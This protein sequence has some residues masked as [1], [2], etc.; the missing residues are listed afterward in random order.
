MNTSAVDNLPQVA[1][2][3]ERHV[4]AAEEELRLEVSFHKQCTCRITL[5]QGSCELQGVELAVGKPTVF[6]D[7]GGLKIALFTWYGCVVDVECGDHMESSYTS[8]ET[9]CNVAYV[10]T[11][12][13]LEA[14]R[15]EAALAAT[16]AAASSAVSSVTAAGG[17]DEN[18]SGNADNAEYRK[19][20]GPRVLICGPAESGKSSLAKVLIAYAVKLGRS[21]VWVDLDPADNNVGVPGTLA[22]C[23]MNTREA[24]SL[25]TW[26]Y[27]GITPVSSEEQLPPT[28]SV[29]G[30]FPSQQQSSSQSSPLMLWHGTAGQPSPDLFK[31]Q[32]TALASKIDR[33]LR[34]DDWARSSG[35]IVNTN[36]WIR[37]EGYQ[38][39][40]HAV[41][42]L[43][44]DVVLVM[45]H[46]RLYSMMRQSIKKGDN[47]GIKVIKVPRSGGVV[48]RDAT[49]LRQ[50]RSRSMKRYF[51]GDLVEASAQ[52]PQPSLSEKDEKT[53][54]ALL[55]PSIAR[56]PQL[57]PYLLKIAADKVN[58]YKF[59]SM[60]LSASLLPVA[61]AQA[62]EA[63]Q[64]TKVEVTEKL[65]HTLLAVCHP[66]AAAAY[67]V[68]GKAADLY[69]A[70][71]AG[72]CA[73]ERV[74]ADTDMLEL[75]SPCAGSLPSNTLLLGD[76]TWMD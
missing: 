30:Q 54:T 35:L 39:L 43:Q 20:Q 33:R 57:T 15:D 16:A 76:I 64:L 53:T 59:S 34:N 11:H 28:S 8:D 47:P 17:G 9:N 56:V 14:L 31:A 52:Q 51:Y 19:T 49:F 36:G 4:L 1:Q 66:T 18:I 61:A 32:V 42:A 69:T 58:I 44:I 3:A 21:P 46:D 67:E 55:A 7:G 25:Q 38:L 5:Q 73:V 65:K 26:A 45:G 74:V 2:G 12:A 40:L 70:G 72:Y 37:D 24:V 60:N 75:L 13:Q 22:A 27:G 62:T 68:S 50:A 71:V 10:N 48:S 6:A 29:N 23:P 41:K 63:V